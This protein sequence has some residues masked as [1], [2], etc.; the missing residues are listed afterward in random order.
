MFYDKLFCKIKIYND[1]NKTD[2][3][4]KASNSHI[5]INLHEFNIEFIGTF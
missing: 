1:E 5:I 2:F 3:N 4:L